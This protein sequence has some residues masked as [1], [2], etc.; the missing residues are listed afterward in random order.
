MKYSFDYIAFKSN[1]SQSELFGE[2]YEE[3]LDGSNNLAFTNPLTDDITDILNSILIKYSLLTEF[4]MEMLN[5]IFNEFNNIR[6]NIDPNRLKTFQH[7]FTSDNE[8]LLYRINQRGLINIIINPEDCIAFS[9]I[10]NADENNKKFY[11]L[12]QDGDFEKLAYDFFS[13]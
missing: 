8:L 4:Q 7:S 3:L 2:R 1:L 6:I 11:F 13:N 12:Y 10:P 5:K 9:F